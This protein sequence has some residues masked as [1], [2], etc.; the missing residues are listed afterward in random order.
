MISGLIGLS[1]RAQPDLK[2]YAQQLQE[3]ISALGR[4][5]EF[6]RPHSEESRPQIGASTLKGLLHELFRPYT[7]ADEGRIVITGDDV[8]VD[9]RG[10]T[11]MALAFH[12][13][14]TNASKYGGLS[15]ASGGVDVRIGRAG[16]RLVIVW[17]EHGGP[18]LPGP[19]ERSGFGSRLTEM[20][21]IQQL[22]GTFTRHWEAK[23][24]RV[25]IEVLAERL[26]RGA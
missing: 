22:G 15:T 9:D 19:P 24:L 20:S 3:R 13:L 1:S 11:P 10:A 25:E 12:E 5:H 14:A 2:S 4:A 17:T 23:G 18:K 16:S 7:A 26:S 8:A 21:I 6:A